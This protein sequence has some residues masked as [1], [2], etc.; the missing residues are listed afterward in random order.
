MKVKLIMKKIIPVFFLLLLCDFSFGQENEVTKI[1]L[2]RHTETIDDGTRDPK[3]SEKGIERAKKWA[4]VLRSEKIDKVY[5]TDLKRTQALARII[6]NS[7]GIEKINSYKRD[8]D[9]KVFLS[10]VKSKTVVV[11]GHSNTTPFFVNKLIGEEK[12]Q[13]IEDADYSNLFMVTCFSKE[14]VSVILLKIN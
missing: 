14:R 2:L 3:L 9:V 10:E 12:Y 4:A 5:S 1:F 11:S 8:L 6:A 7:Q 13:Q